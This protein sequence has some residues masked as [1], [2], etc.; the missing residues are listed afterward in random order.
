MSL[1]YSWMALER[2]ILAL[3]LT[4]VAPSSSARAGPYI[5]GQ[6]VNPAF[7]ELAGTPV[8]IAAIKAYAGLQGWRIDCE[9]QVDTFTT[10]RLRFPP[11][12]TQAAIES[13]FFTDL[14]LPSRAFKIA[15]VYDEK[16]RW[17][18]GCIIWP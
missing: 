8:Q 14:R 6:L 5:G 10:L 15:M 2:L 18:T 1:D 4:I 12:T 11:G 3:C 17:P 13:Y 7:V 16:Q 9:G